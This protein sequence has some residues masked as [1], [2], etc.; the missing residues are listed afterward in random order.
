MISTRSP[1]GAR[2]LGMLVLAVAFAAGA[3]AAT[4]VGRVLHADPAATSAESGGTSCDEKR[5]H[6]LDRLDLSTEQREEIDGILERRRA[7]ADRFWSDAEPTLNA[8]M[9]STRAEIREVLTPAQRDEYDR[10]RRERKAAER[11]EREQQEG[12]GTD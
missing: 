12:A 5:G 9:D 3:V 11:A 8:I 1:R 4:A 6:L 2:A 10:L 7:Q